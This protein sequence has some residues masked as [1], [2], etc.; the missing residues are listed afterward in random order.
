MA[1][2]K[3]KGVPIHGWLAIDKPAGMTSTQVVTR[4]KH[5]TQAQKAG[6]GGTLDPLATGVL[7]LALGEA[8][9]TVAYVMD[10]PKTYRF[11]VRFGEAR[12]TDDA[13]GRP[14]ATSDRRP[15]DAEIQAALA[16]FR[17]RD[18]AAAAALRGHQGA[19]RAGLRHRPPRR[20]DRARAETR[21]DRPPRHGRTGRIRITPISR[22][23]AA[24]APMSGALARDLGEQLGCFA[25]VAAL[26]RTSVGSFVADRAISLDALEQL[27]AMMRC[28]RS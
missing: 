14:T 24:R 25:H 19:W 1:R 4:V 20:G 7:P 22:W 13:E 28:P 26:R 27:V 5:L 10:A 23:P 8:T 2:R 9:K 6:H 18:R 16:G 17:R 21:P 15:G 3:V 11:R 12:D